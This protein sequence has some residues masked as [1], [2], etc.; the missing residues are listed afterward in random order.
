[1]KCPKGTIGWRCS[2]WRSPGWVLLCSAAWDGT[3][4]L[5]LKTPTEQR[6]GKSRAVGRR[7]GAAAQHRH[8]SVPPRGAC[9]AAEQTN[10]LG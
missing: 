5:I 10:V 6:G 4:A 9:T 3:E 2:S 7:A 1:M 8:S